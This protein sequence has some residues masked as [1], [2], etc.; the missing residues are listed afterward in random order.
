MGGLWGEGVRGYIRVMQ[1]GL[2][3]QYCGMVSEDLVV[4]I[5]WEGGLPD[6]GLGALV[7]SNP[8]LKTNGF[9]YFVTSILI[10]NLSI[11]F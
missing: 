2:S 4:S 8:Q 11:F 1:P 5:W 3:P 6:Q 9:N 7:I 10:R